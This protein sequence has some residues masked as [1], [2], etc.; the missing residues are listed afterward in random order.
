VAD[1]YLELW[2]PQL[3]RARKFF[4]SLTRVVVS[5]SGSL[6]EID[7]QL[8]TVCLEMDQAGIEVVWG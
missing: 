6:E 2:L 3:A 8:D 1:R 4:D 5:F 7:P